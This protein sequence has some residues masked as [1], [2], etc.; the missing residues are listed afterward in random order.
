MQEMPR[1]AQNEAH[2]VLLPIVRSGTV[3]LERSASQKH[4]DTALPIRQ[5]SSVLFVTLPLL[6]LDPDIGPTAK[7]VVGGQTTKHYRIDI[8][9]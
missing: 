3:A 8:R 6:P 7:V 2:R 1:I 5:S 9:Q 4:P